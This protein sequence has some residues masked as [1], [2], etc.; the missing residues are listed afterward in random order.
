MA[1][2]RSNL[3][4]MWRAALSTGQ[5]IGIGWWAPS[6]MEVVTN[7]GC[8]SVT[9]MP[10]GARSIRNDSRNVLSAALLAL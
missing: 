2:A 7:P 10:T 3:R 9:W 8:T 5:R 4:T 6:M 1:G